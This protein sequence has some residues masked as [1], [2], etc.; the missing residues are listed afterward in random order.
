V[1]GGGA[2]ALT[3]LVF[4]GCGGRTSSLD[5]EAYDPSG[6][7]S[8]SGGGSRGGSGG[9]A[10]TAGAGAAPRGGAGGFDPSLATAPCQAYCAGYGTQ[11]AANLNGLDCPTACEAE[12]NVAGGRCQALGLETIRCLTPFFT[13]GGTGCRAASN[14][15][16][17]VCGKLA[18]EFG[19]CK[20]GTTAPPTMPT[21]PTGG[22]DVTASCQR[23]ESIST[24]TGCLDIYVCGNQGYI[25]QCTKDS[26]TSAVR[27]TCGANEGNF[28]QGVGCADVARTLCR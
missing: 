2:V 14:R 26:E 24:Q 22:L 6:F 3:A 5:P 10:S 27:C 12:L 4:S 16:L 21:A 20:T 8:S 28:T 25:V 15:G 1:S 17:A 7:G 19:K 9:N 23:A 13:P 11:C 18:D